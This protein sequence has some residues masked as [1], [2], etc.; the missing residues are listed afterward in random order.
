MYL[1][2]TI[3]VADEE[4]LDEYEDKYCLNLSEPNDDVTGKKNYLCISEEFPDEFE[5]ITDGDIEEDS[6]YCIR[7]F[8]PSTPEWSNNF[9]CRVEDEIRENFGKI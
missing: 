1:V 8:E 2:S 6:E 9:I 7:V 5:F 3:L 4:E